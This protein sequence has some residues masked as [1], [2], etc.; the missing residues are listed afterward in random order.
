MDG[1][2]VEDITGGVDDD[3]MGGGMDGYKLVGGIIMGGRGSL[4]SEACLDLA[5]DP[6]L[7]G[8]DPCLVNDPF[9]DPGPGPATSGMLG[10]EVGLKN[11]GCC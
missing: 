11:A 1:G 10:S 3:D 6:R 2:A 4:D 5:S 8:T 9:L 7:L